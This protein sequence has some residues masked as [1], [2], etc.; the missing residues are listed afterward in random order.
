MCCHSSILQLRSLERL[1]G[2]S[3]EGEAAQRYKQR[4]FHELCQGS[5]LRVFG[6][7]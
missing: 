2:P 7:Y 6:V 5:G 3:G 1:V 4:A